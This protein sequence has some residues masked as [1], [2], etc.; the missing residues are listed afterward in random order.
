MSRYFKFGSLLI[1]IE[2]EGNLKIIVFYLEK[3]KQSH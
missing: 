3:D 2:I 1:P